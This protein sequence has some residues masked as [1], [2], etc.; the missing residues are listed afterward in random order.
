MNED[1]RSDK[2][3]KIALKQKWLIDFF[4]LFER[5]RSRMQEVEATV[6]P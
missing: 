5:F 6:N 3:I 1:V 4:P 2:L